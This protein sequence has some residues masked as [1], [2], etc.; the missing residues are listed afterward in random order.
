MCNTI[1]KLRL[2]ENVKIQKNV[3]E[4]TNILTNSKQIIKYQKF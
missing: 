1:E 2:P 4:T 3:D